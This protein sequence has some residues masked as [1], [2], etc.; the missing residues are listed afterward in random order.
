MWVVANYVT[1]LSAVRPTQLRE[2]VASCEDALRDLPHD[3]CARFLAHVKA[4]ACAVLGDKLGL[5]ET[6]SRYRSYFDCKENRQEWF[7]GGRQH[8]LADIPMMVR[9]LEQNERALYRKM[10]WG[11][12]WKHIS[13]S[14]G[15]PALI[16]GSNTIPWWVWWMLIWIVLQLLRNS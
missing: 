12:R 16:N 7:S 4:E 9:F 2:I 8:L 1:C 15:T 10:V 11:L 13:R 5:R 3:H 14:L 6:W